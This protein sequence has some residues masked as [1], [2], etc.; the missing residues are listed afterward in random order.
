[1]GGDKS[2]LL[3]EELEALL[4]ALRAG[5]ELPSP[6]LRARILARVAKPV[7]LQA[8]SPVTLRAEQGDWIELCPGVLSKTLRHDGVTRT[9]L[10]RMSAG[11]CIPAHLHELDEECLVLEGTVHFDGVEFRRGDYHLAPAGSRHE[12]VHSANGCLCLLRTESHLRLEGV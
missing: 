1:M 12:V 11:A 5:V 7:S 10:A 9:W 4:L 2:D 3:R 6:G 8:A